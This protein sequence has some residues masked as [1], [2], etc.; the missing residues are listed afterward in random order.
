[1]LLYTN[2][3]KSSTTENM[4]YETLSPLDID[5]AVEAEKK[6]GEAKYSTREEDGAIYRRSPSPK[7]VVRLSQ[8]DRRSGPEGLTIDKHPIQK[9]VNATP[10]DTEI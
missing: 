8:F 6:A 5:K 1:M 3:V 7:I 10:P 4:N 2:V 9:P